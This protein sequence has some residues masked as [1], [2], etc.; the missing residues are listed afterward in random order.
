MDLETI[1]Y[2]FLNKLSEQQKKVCISMDNILLTA[3]PGSGKTRT[4]SYKLAYLSKKHKQSKALNIAITYTNRAADEIKKR[5]LDLEVD[6]DNIWAG[7]IHQFCLEFVIRPYSMYCTRIS[8]G[9]HIIDEYVSDQYLKEIAMDLRIAIGF[10]DRP[11]NHSE[12][13]QVYKLRLIDNKELDFDDILEVSFHLIDTHPFIGQNIAGILRSLLIDEYQDTNQRQY[14][15]ISRITLVNKKIQ[16]M[17]VGD[18]DQAIYGGIGGVVKNKDDLEKGLGLPFVEMELDGCYRSTQRIIDFYS[19][20]QVKNSPIHAL[21]EIR[22]EDGWI[23][24][25]H[26]IHVS[27]LS[28]RV[29]EIVAEQID[30][31]IPEEEIC[32]VAPQWWILSLL[33]KE[34]QECLPDV[35]FDSPEIRP[36]KYDPMNVFYLICKLI[37]TKPGIDTWLRKKIANEIILRLSDDYNISMPVGIDNYRLLKII[38]SVNY[39]DLEGISYIK[40]SVKSIFTELKINLK[41]E[42][43]LRKGYADFIAKTE[44]RVSRHALATDIETIRKGFK[45]RK[46]V[47]IS[48]FH[49]VKG[50]EFTTVIALGI[51][52][53]YIPNW[54]I[55][56][57]ETC[58]YCISETKKLL[59]VVCSRAKRNLFL[60]SEIGRTTRKGNSLTATDELA[61]Y[62]YKYDT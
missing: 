16:V 1:E 23:S 54:D 53:G 50:E 52:K 4:L 13:A 37:F 25:D 2:P 6:M 44:D 38:N 42:E 36:I 20:F 28:K 11:L 35:S 32:I 14:E 61:N 58:E 5:L 39:N 29:V 56:I 33:G 12:I 31:G 19:N 10:G 8:K 49:G 41:L 34:I 3:C 43:K 46:G 17:F 40:K 60:F 57:N 55:V 22:D 15:I 45:D 51:L 18:T 24:Y 7:T 26:Q 21:S 9:Y 62:C 27:S 59:Y 47:V 30:Q 48:T